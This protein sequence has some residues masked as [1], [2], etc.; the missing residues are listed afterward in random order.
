MKLTRNTVRCLALVLSALFSHS[1][2]ATWSIII[3]DSAT[4]EVAIASATCVTGIDLKREASTVVVGKG[5]GAAQNFVDGSGQNRQ[6]IF[7][8]LQAGTA[9]ADILDALAQQDAQ[10][11]TRQYGIA[12]TQAR[13]VGFSGT[14]SG[15]FADDITGQSGT[16][17][18]A[19]QGNVLTG[20]PVLT[21]AEA[22]ILSPGGDLPAKLMRAMLASRN[23][24]GDG[25]CSCSPFNPEGCGSPP[26]D[27]DKSADVGYMVVARLG[28]QDGNCNANAGCASGDY[29]MDL[30]VAFASSND[31]DP[32]FTLR[33]QFS[34]WRAG[35]VERP[36]HHRSRA[37]LLDLTLPP[38]GNSSTTMIL[39]ARD[40]R[41]TRI[42]EGGANVSVS[43][44]AQSTATATVGAVVDN[45]NGIYL[46]PVT[47]DNSAGQV[48]FDVTIDDGVRPV[49]LSPRPTLTLESF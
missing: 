46:V 37:I 38:D 39:V 35:L 8:E 22:A 19:I 14:A 41:G 1:G 30:N 27:F 21:A 12:D 33:N 24:G 13:A 36:D 20:E 40:F 6:L 18:Y 15:G 45:G 2:W 11:Q 34:A 3:T 44:N 31:P 32:V 23:Q 7:A 10:H 17:S 5:A 48:L 16:L 47:A 25:R 26:A 42:T 9:P 49:Q 43:V 4:D 29:Y 28:D